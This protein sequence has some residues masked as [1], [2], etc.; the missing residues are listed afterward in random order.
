MDVQVPEEINR[1]MLD[2]AGGKGSPTETS[3]ETACCSK[4][5][6]STG[7]SRRAVRCE[8]YRH[9]TGPKTD[10]PGVLRRPG[11][12]EQNYSAVSAY[13]ELFALRPRTSEW[14]CSGQDDKG[15]VRE[16]KV[17]AKSQ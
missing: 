10:A 3:L 16:I 4:D 17:S 14:F 2:R 1:R 11:L 9:S 15:C 12:S 7:L 5:W 8:A 6:P 13:C